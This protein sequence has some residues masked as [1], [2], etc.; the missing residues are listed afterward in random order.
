MQVTMLYWL[1]L[2]EKYVMKSYIVMSPVCS[3]FKIA[4]AIP[5]ILCFH[6]NLKFFSGYMNHI[7]SILVGI[8]LSCGSL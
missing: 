1:P 8:A 3:L 7:I 4:L 5:G 2:L 6:V